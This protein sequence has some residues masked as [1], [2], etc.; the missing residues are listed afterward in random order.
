MVIAFNLTAKEFQARPASSMRLVVLP[1][2]TPLIQVQ[3]NLA[4]WV[5]SS[6]FQRKPG[7]VQQP[8][9]IYAQ[10]SGALKYLKYKLLTLF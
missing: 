7:N 6:L 1:H 4:Q 9:N 3:I 10:L 8:C 5:E 2:R